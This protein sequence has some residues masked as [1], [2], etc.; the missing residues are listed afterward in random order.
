MMGVVILVA[1]SAK[2]SCDT[3]GRL[4][5]HDNDTF[6][7]LSSKNHLFWEIKFKL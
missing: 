2:L 5:Q 6:P 3:E 4:W 1:K 7:G